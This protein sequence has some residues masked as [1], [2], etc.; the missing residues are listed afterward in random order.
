MAHYPQLTRARR[1][2]TR[3]RSEQNSAAANYAHI[4]GD[5]RTSSD[6]FYAA[7][8]RLALAGQA[9]HAATV[10]EARLAAIVGGL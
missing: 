2:L 10:A 7:E 9:L 6:Q 3:A 8:E 4:M 5:P 1:N